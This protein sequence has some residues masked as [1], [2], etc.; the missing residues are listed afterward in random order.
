[1]SV[2]KRRQNGHAPVPRKLRKVTQ[3]L[4]EGKEPVSD[5]GEDLLARALATQ[6]DSEDSSS[7]EMDDGHDRSNLQNTETPSAADPSSL[8]S[9]RDP[10]FLQQEPL[11]HQI[12]ALLASVRTPAASSSRARPLM[13]ALEEI[14]A[15]LAS[16]PTVAPLGIAEAIARLSKHNVTIPFPEP[17]P[18]P[19][20]TQWQLAFEAPASIELVG[21]WPVGTACRWKGVQGWGVDMALQL[22]A[23]LLQENDYKQGRYLHKRAYYVACLA[24]ALPARL[25]QLHVSIDLLHGDPRR[26]MIA[27]VPKQGSLLAKL[28]VVIR[29]LPCAG[30]ESPMPLS[31]LNPGRS[32]TKS[33]AGTTEPT[34]LYNSALLHDAF[35]LADRSYLEDVTESCPAFKDACLLLKVWAHQ[36]HVTYA[37]NDPCPSACWRTAERQG[38]K[39]LPKTASSWQLFSAVIDFLAE[40]SLARRLVF[41]KSDTPLFS[42]DEL[43]AAYMN[44][45]IDHTGSRNLLAGI[46]SANL[47][48]LQFAS[49]MSAIAIAMDPS[50]AFSSV[51]LRSSFD[52][53]VAFDVTVV[54]DV[55]HSVTIPQ[56]PL[57]EHRAQHTLAVL[58]S[59]TLVRGLSD[60]ITCLSISTRSH[61]SSGSSA[62]GTPS[63]LTVGLSLNPAQAQ[64]LI[65]SGPSAEDATAA[66]KFRSFWGER[67]ELRRF[68][69]GSI[70]ESVVW[71]ADSVLARSRIIP[72]IINYLMSK[73]L[74]LSPAAISVIAGPYDALLMQPDCVFEASAS[75]NP[76]TRGFGAVMGAFDELAKYLRQIEKLPL[77]VT[78]VTPA[79]EA[80]RY[81]SV[82]L[83]SP[84]DR[85]T[86]AA[87]ALPT[88]AHTA[89]H[90]IAITLESSGHWP[91]DL[92]AVQK[93]KAAFL[94]SLAETLLRTGQYECQIVFDA[95]ALPLVDH[96]ALDI[97]APTGYAFRARIHHDGDKTLLERTLLDTKSPPTPDERKILLAALTHHHRRYVVN[98][99]HH[100]AIAALQLRFPTLSTSVRILK[101]W[102]AA[103]MLSPHVAPELAELLTAY[104]YLDPTSSLARPG[105]PATAFA[106]AIDLLSAWQWLDTPLLI[107]LYTSIGLAPEVRAVLP[108]KKEQ[109]ARDAFVRMRKMDPAVQR[110]AMV[111]VTEEDLEGNLY[112]KDKPTRLVAARIVQLAQATLQTIRAE[113]QI[114]KLDV[115]SMFK[116]PLAHYDLLIHLDASQLPRYAESISPRQHLLTARQPRWA[117]ANQAD[118]AR[119]V[120]LGFDPAQ[121]LV[122]TLEHFYGDAVVFFHDVHGGDV[123]GALVNPAILKE[124]DFRLGLGYP[125]QPADAS[126]SAGKVKIIASLASM[127]G[128]IRRLGGKLVTGVSTNKHDQLVWQAA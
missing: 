92:H 48:A 78:S 108:I 18:S 101:R 110:S 97:L 59:D 19:L 125:C 39:K 36:Q 2:T 74:K 69:D 14:K 57:Y 4:R 85:A 61:A 9:T 5:D 3:S 28:R 33:A 44:G 10:H 73:H 122:R 119:S 80:L 70:T 84:R 114:G 50:A 82:F 89:L 116:T 60:R 41:A 105:S 1:M 27:L 25:S 11:Q 37:H 66:S 91:S 53:A 52:P 103:H 49:R 102:L 86:Y 31:K 115:K 6:H 40:T 81:S 22:P 65:D 12:E 17:G 117:L 45:F 127:I 79:S 96:C 47:D 26:P 7:S 71:T 72:Q 51:L 67:S 123:I 30:A 42:P 121:N 15:T 120:P 16:L 93:I 124:R 21:S 43:S 58:V 34:P 68:Q 128:E 38:Y 98:P 77:S 106:R 118:G 56:D 62:A 20:Q 24:A 113:T 107:P 111:L 99:R 54:L 95:D 29:L 32:N 90:D 109:L 13:L 76:K 88:S 104:V 63:Q 112:T 46:P 75:D 83:P 8:S 64:R 35:L 87:K 55:G 94:L 23:S 100:A 126:E